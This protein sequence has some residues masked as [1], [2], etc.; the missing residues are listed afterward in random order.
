MRYDVCVFGGCALDQMYYLDDEKKVPENPDILVPGG[1]GANQAVAAARAGART[2]IITRIGKDEIG[3]NILENLAY[4][5]ITTNN[6]EVVESLENDSSKI[7]IDNVSK[8]N[9]IERFSGAINSFTTDMIER[10]RAVLLSSRIVVAQMKIPK[11]VSVELINFCY[12]NQVPIIITPCRPNKLAINDEENKELIDKITYITCNEEECKIIFNT[13]NIEECLNKYPNKLIVTLGDKGIKYNDGTNIV[14]LDAIDVTKVEDTTGAGDTFNGN[15]AYCLANGYSLYDGIVR[16][17]FASAMKIQ[18]KTAQ[19]GMPYKEELD[20]YIKGY[21]LEDS[22]YLD[23]FDLAYSAVVNAANVIKKKKIINIKVKEDSSFVTESDL[24][25][26]K[27]IINKIIEQ[28]PRDN[29]VTEETNSKNEIKDR[30][31]IIDPIDG[32]AHY[33][34]NSIFWG[35]QLAFVDKGE[36]K[37]S[38][39]YLPKLNEMYYA[40]KGKGTYLN[41]KRIK[42]ENNMP[43]NQCIVEFCGSMRNKFEEKLRLYNIIENNDIKVANYMHINSCSFAFC[44]ILA[45]R[46]NAMVLSTEKAWD[47]V[48]GMFLLEEAGIE[49]ANFENLRVFS[50]SKEFIDLINGK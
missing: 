31:W 37:F 41:H 22:D 32:T 47:I 28:Y 24:L 34:K 18:K 2:T 29:F 33:M 36:V 43:L 5:G 45:K 14:H 44:N 35:I 3:Q 9:K 6:V 27:Y 8:D 46:T 48:P 1:K 15:L 21:I 17:Q 13:D 26:E 30:T 23:E 19:E 38:V 16:A 20:A 40:V 4:N 11:E 12:K 25:V 49:K 10:Y 42:M 39:I 7:Y 50:D